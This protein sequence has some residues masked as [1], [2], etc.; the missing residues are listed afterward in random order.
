[1]QQSNQFRRRLRKSLK[2]AA[3]AKAF[4]LLE[5]MKQSLII[6]EISRWR[7]VLAEIQATRTE[8]KMGV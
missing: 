1:L 6:A 5:Y 3:N 4:V 8:R 2:K 7:L